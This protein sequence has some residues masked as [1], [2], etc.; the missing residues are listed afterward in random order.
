M[1]IPMLPAVFLPI[2]AAVVVLVFLKHSGVSSP[3]VTGV[4]VAAALVLTIM[5]TVLIAL[6]L[7]KK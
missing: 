4:A 1:K 3:R 6:Y 5:N 7:S 2:I